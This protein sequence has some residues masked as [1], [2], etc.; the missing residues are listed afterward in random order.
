MF[1][2]CRSHGAKGSHI[3][4]LICAV[5]YHANVPIFAVDGDFEQYAP[6]IPITLYP[7]EANSNRIH[8]TQA[9]YSLAS[10]EKRAWH[11]DQKIIAEAAVLPESLWKKQA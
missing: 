1:N 9:Q 4:F 10:A 8:D 5:A 2:T 3:G 7:G 6:Y 11:D